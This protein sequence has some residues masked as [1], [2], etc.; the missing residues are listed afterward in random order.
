MSGTLTTL[1]ENTSISASLMA[2]HGLS[3]HIETGEHTILF[4]TGQSDKL[5]ENARV[6]GVDL[7]AI[8]VVVISHGHYDH[9]GGVPALL[10]HTSP[11]RLVTGHGFFTPKY[12]DDA[13]GL[14]YNGVSFSRQDLIDHRWTHEYVG[15]VPYPL[16]SP[17]DGIYLVSD[18]PREDRFERIPEVFL[19]K[20]PSGE[21]VPDLFTDEVLLVI[22]S[23]KG[24][25]VFVGCSHPG[26]INMI[27]EVKR[28]FKAPIYG[29]FGGT[30]LNGASDE[31]IDH[32]AEFFAAEQIE[33]LGVSHCTGEHARQR[34]AADGLQVFANHAGTITRW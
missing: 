1:I 29:L 26:I 8:D 31:R 25:L 5:L 3:M 15:A 16:F 19:Q 20:D 9:A 13:R 23:P 30:H 22:E 4:D 17:E 33:L 18:F 12:A 24:L 10:E 21:M 7:D 11:K 32:A 34:M 27:E 6:L 14:R 2:E 28:L